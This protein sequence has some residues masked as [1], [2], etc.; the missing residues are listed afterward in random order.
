MSHCKKMPWNISHKWK[1]VNFHQT[2]WWF[3]QTTFVLGDREALDLWQ[4]F[5]ELSIENLKQV[6]QVD[7]LYFLDI[8]HRNFVFSYSIFIMMNINR[9]LNLVNKANKSS[10]NWTNLVI[11]NNVPMAL[12]KPSF[13]LNTILSHEMLVS[14]SRNQMEL[15]FTLHGEWR[16]LSDP[17]HVE[18]MLRFTEN[19]V[20]IL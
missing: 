19:I 2:D 11:V 8:C 17:R 6:Y 20:A 15:L 13:P 18:F 7:S 16:K 5:R 10:I 12:L 9:N 4:K 3:E 1:Q 14:L